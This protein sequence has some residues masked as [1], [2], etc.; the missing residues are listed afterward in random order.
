MGILN[1]TKDS[2]YDGGKY[3]NLNSAIAHTQ[4]MLDEGAYFI[5]IGVSSSK[6]GSLLIS[7]EEEKNRLIPFLKVLLKEF[8]KTHFSLDTYNS[9]V[10]EES[11]DL[12][13]SMIND[14]SGGLIDPN[15]LSIVGLHKVPY[16]IMHMK[17]MPKSMQDDIYYQNTVQE[18][19]YFF[20]K[21]IKK[22]SSAGINDIIIDPG[23]GFGKSKKNNFTLLQNLSYFENLKCPILIGIS[24]K[25]MVYKTLGIGPDQSLNGT[26]ALN[27]W[28]LDRGAKILRVHDVK[29]A[30][31]CI[32]LWLELQ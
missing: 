31:E 14:I 32:D 6:P 18:I 19:T 2:F 23:F 13:I 20:S 8:P 12:G 1:L 29:E 9:L 17:G 3:N 21:Q 10:A 5:D 26:T 7:T 22:A 28:G 25:S 11:L 27:A 4:K 30:K 24:R 15:I 16:V